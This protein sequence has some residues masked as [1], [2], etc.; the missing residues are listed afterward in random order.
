MTDYSKAKI[1]KIKPKGEHPPEDEYIGST[2][3]KYLSSRMAGHK[4]SFNCADGRG[5][6][7]D[8]LFNKYGL[9]ECEIELIEE[10]SC[11]TKKELLE[12]EGYLIT[13]TPCINQKNAGVN[14]KEYEKKKNRDYYLKNQEVLRKNALER[15][16]KKKYIV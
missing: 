16:N 3:K 8:G 14:R 13:Q 2:T 1:Y 9:D 5:S 11:K 15:F 4:Y 12:R 6:S 10:Y 7:V